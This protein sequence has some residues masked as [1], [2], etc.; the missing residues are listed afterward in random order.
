[1]FI[2]TKIF[3]LKDDKQSTE[4]NNW[5]KNNSDIT[6]ISTNTFA[7]GYGWGYIIMYST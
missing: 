3:V 4:I 7:N 5:L 6:I 2:Q 1:M